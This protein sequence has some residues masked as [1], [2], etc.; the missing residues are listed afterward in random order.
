MF[1]H[2]KR[3]QPF[4][5]CFGTGIGIT[6]DL[7]LVVYLLSIAGTLLRKFLYFST[8][9]K[10]LINFYMHMTGKPVFLSIVEDCKIIRIIVDICH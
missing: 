8:E 3:F 1:P 10:G 4:E 7:E 5:Q 9:S 2:K 6:S